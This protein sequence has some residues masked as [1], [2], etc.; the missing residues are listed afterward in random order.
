MVS[1]EM[2]AGMI[3]KVFEAKDG[4]KVTLRSPKWD[5][6]D[7]LMECINSLVEEGVDIL[8]DE[9]QT[10]EGEVDWLARVLCKI[11]R[12]ERIGVVCEVGG[13]VVGNS[14]VE[15][16]SARRESHVGSLGISIRNGYRDSGIGTEM[17]RALVNESR[18]AGLK[19]LILDV[20]ATNRRA[21]HV[22]EKVGFREVGK[23]PK[24]VFKDGEYIDLIRIVLEL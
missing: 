15:R 3:Y 5:D 17:M 7:D 16:F 4:R 20:F 18:K 24:A 9:K 14:E 1:K 8:V 12:G 23:M 11:E 19:L 2:R 10:R 21:K 6:L 13:K 22:Y